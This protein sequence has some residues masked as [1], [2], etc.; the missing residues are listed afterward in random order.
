MGNIANDSSRVMLALSGYESG[1]ATLH[2]CILHHVLD[3]GSPE[4]ELK[5][6]DSTGPIAR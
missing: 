6:V 2:A 1:D 4:W 5:K 3:G